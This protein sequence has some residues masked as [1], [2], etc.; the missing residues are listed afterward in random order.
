MH[1]HKLGLVLAA[2][3]GGWHLVWRLLVLL[4]WAQA[5]TVG[6]NRVSIL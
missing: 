3:I 5:L 6:A 4:G 2:L 1:A